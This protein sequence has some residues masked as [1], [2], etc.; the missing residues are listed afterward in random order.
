MKPELGAPQSTR[1]QAQTK[2]Q[3]LKISENTLNCWQGNQIEAVG[4]FQKDGS[5][6][7]AM[8][9]LTATTIR[10]LNVEQDGHAET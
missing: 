8:Q 1:T 4:P 5:R 7:F 3:P 6:E 10:S 9:I 2:P